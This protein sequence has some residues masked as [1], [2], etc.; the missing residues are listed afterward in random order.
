MNFKNLEWHMESALLEAEKAYRVDE[1]PIGALVVDSSGSI[2]AQAHNEKESVHDPCGH[3]EIIALRK[4]AE[5]IK[6]WRLSGCS[7]I[8]TLEP[9]PMC[10]SAALHA[11]VDRVV[12]GAYD[13]KGG[14]MSLGYNLYKD[15]RLNHE[16]SVIGG[17]MHYKCSNL[18]SSFFRE[19]RKFHS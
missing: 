7:L 6:N 18:L 13:S 10:L 1:V 4:A 17:V 19:K 5:N 14:S 8:V 9:C 16:F 2:L 15:K 11:R 3:A 12:F